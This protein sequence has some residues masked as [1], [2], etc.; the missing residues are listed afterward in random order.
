[1]VTG[2]VEPTSEN[3]TSWMKAGVFCV[4]MGSKLFPKDKIAEKDWDY[5]TQ[6]MSGSPVV[7]NPVR[8]IILKTLFILVFCIF[9]RIE[10]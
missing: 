2:G 1:M 5:I 7:H 6:D 3:I 4:G 10:F 9:V 8:S